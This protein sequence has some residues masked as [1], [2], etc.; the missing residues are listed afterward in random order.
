MPK[1]SSNPPKQKD[2]QQLARA[3]LDAVV[4]DAEPP[5]PEAAKPEKNPAAVALGRLGGLK[6]GPARMAKLSPAKRK[7]IA[8]KAAAKRWGSKAD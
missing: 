2:T 1:R 6:G 4:L 3:T 7:A 8:K 5:K